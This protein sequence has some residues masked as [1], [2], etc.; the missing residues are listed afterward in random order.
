MEKRV[1][2]KTTVRGNFENVTM[3]IRERINQKVIY[4]LRL[5]VGEG[6]SCK[7]Y[8]YMEEVF[9]EGTIT[10]VLWLDHF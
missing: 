2:E 7:L 6:A 5:E 10:Q 9:Q 8:R 4:D 3:V 1:I